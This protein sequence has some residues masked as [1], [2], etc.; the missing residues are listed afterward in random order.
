[1]KKYIEKLEFNKVLDVLSNF[2]VTHIGKNLVKSLEPS[3]DKEIVSNLLKET[4]EATSLIYKKHSPNFIDICDINDIAKTLEINGV[5]GTKSLLDVSKILSL[6]S[7]LKQY[8]NLDNENPEIVFP[9]LEKYFSALYIN[10][11]I[12]EAI[13]KSI[14]DENTIADDASRELANIRRNQRKLEENIKN[15]LHS[16]I[17]SAS[18]SK[19]IQ[20]NI[21]TVRND[22]YVIPVKDEYRSMINGFIHDVS[23]SGST[24]FIEPMVIFEL[25]NEM[26]TLK[27]NEAIEIEKILIQL[28]SLLY[29]IVNELKS[30]YDLIGLLDFIFAKG[31]YSLEL[32]AI[33]P[34]INN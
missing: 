19:Y 14:L 30:D 15:K 31:K 26:A 20:E 3:N 29:P 7:C 4:S 11:S 1:M 2:C 17:H 9:I 25:N 23:S 16:F 21:I 22:R 27:A 10:P 28:S 6:A 34:K 33:E 18:Y 32:D 13:E 8:F 12:Q 24:V 5:L